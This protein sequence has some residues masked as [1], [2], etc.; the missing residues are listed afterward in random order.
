M[1]RVIGL[2]IDGDQLIQQPGGFLSIRRLHLRN[3]RD[4]GS[5]SRPY[6]CDFHVRPMGLDAVV[7]A[8]WHR[9]PRGVEV[10]L[11]DGLRPPLALGRAADRQV[12]PDA[13]EYLFLTELVAGILEEHDRGDEGLRRRAADEVLEEAGY[14]V[15]PAAIVPLGHGLFPSPGSAAEKFFL[16]AAEIADPADQHPLEGDGSP[17][18]EGAQVRWVLLEEALAM[19]AR[20]EIEDCKTEIGLRRLKDLLG[21]A[22]P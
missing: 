22:A 4:D 1:H 11:R 7:V 12:V 2:Q 14:R 19:C 6:V 13:R 5:L 21:T 20:G 17:M 18:E 8:I 15:D 3:R 10:L 9:G 16:M